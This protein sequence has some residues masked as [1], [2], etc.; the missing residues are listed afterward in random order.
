MVNWHLAIPV[1]SQYHPNMKI[2]HMQVY[3]PKHHHAHIGLPYFL[4]WCN[5][6]TVVSSTNGKRG[7]GPTTFTT[8]DQ[9]SIFLVKY[10]IKGTLNIY[11]CIK[12]WEF[13]K[14]IYM[15]ITCPSAR[16]NIPSFTNRTCDI[17][18]FNLWN[19]NKYIFLYW[20]MS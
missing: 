18:P 17:S 20:F 8:L 1:Y 6:S 14:K 4:Y 19:I 15:P 12:I 10:G 2:L 13:L 11:K 7:F 9:D 16:A 3:S 5:I